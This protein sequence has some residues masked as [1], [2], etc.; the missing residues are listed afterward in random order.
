MRKISKSVDIGASVERVFD[1]A[2][3]PENLPTIWPSLVE[4]T[5]AARRAD[6]WHSFDWTYRMAGV[7]FHGS[8]KTVRVETNAYCAVKSEGGIPSVFRWSYEDRDGATRVTLDV[9][10]AIPL[11][12]LGKVAEA[13]VANINEREADTMLGNLKL[14]LEG[15]PRAR[16]GEAA[17]AHV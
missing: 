17:R 2:T 3:Q 7:R 5:K 14:A 16:P 11:P 6:G 13:I 10:Y 4:V 15:A 8:A 9:E 1:F 12:V